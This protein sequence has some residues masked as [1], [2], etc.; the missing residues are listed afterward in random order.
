MA[1][2]YPVGQVVPGR[3][4]CGFKETESTKW[5]PEYREYGITVIIASQNQQ[6]ITAALNA[7]EVWLKQFGKESKNM[8]VL[9]IEMQ[10]KEGQSKVAEQPLEKETEA[11]AINRYNAV[12]NRYET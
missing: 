11:G 1:N 3:V 4:V 9:G 12:F 6:K 10:Y 8:N 7:V 2:M 5:K